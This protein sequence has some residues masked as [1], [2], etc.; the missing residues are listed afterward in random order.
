M[1][2]VHQ[3]LYSAKTQFRIFGS[4]KFAYFQHYL[5]LKCAIF[6]VKRKIYLFGHIKECDFTLLNNF[7]GILKLDPKKFKE[8]CLERTM[9]FTQ[10]LEKKNFSYAKV[11]K[12]EQQNRP[13]VLYLEFH[14][15]KAEAVFHKEHSYATI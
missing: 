2:V 1:S 12:V 6:Y 8:F 11:W 9:K 4:I 14:R 5:E 3:T 10:L 7:I 13:F 15:Q